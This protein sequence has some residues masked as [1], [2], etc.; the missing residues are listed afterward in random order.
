MVHVSLGNARAEAGSETVTEVHMIFACLAQ[1]KNRAS[2]AAVEGIPALFADRVAG[3]GAASPE[4]IDY[5]VEGNTSVFFYMADADGGIACPVPAGVNIRESVKNIHACVC[6]AETLTEV[7]HACV[8]LAEEPAG[9]VLNIVVRSGNDGE[10]RFLGSE[11]LESLIQLPGIESL[12]CISV[13][14]LCPDRCSVGG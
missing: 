8:R 14:I 10:L 12:C 5:R 9:L 3:D 13:L 6:A 4:G 11:F 1:R 2:T 7:G